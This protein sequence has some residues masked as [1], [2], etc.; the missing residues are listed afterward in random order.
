LWFPFEWIIDNGK[1]IIKGGLR[2]HPIYNNAVRL[3]NLISHHINS[4]GNK[5]FGK[6]LT[7]PL[8]RNY[9]LSIINYQLT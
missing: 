8:D 3:D 2:P 9:Q 6:K 4:F 5:T 1:W 7:Y